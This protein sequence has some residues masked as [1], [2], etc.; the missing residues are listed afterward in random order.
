MATNTLVLF[1]MWGTLL[2]SVGAWVVTLAKFMWQTYEEAKVDQETVC[3]SARRATRQALGHVVLSP[4]LSHSTWHIICVMP[5]LY[6]GWLFCY[7]FR[8]GKCCTAWT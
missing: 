7:R 5:S 2:A 1:A 4:A 6:L 8:A 3:E